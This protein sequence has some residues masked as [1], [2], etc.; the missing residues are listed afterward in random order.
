MP[1]ECTQAERDELAAAIKAGARTVSYSGP[2]GDKRVTFESRAEMLATLAEMDEFLAGGS[3][4][5]VRHSR[6][7]FDRR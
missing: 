6:V 1:L 3:T 4:P 7:A 2:T 5:V